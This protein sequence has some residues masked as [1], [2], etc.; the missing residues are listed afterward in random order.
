MRRPGGRARSPEQRRTDRIIV[1]EHAAAF[2]MLNGVLAWLK[3]TTW[4]AAPWDWWVPLGWGAGLA[5]HA[6]WAF[7]RLA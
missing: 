5:V 4:P 7:G 6:L 2:V 3:L 1:A